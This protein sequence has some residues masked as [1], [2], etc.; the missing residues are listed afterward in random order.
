MMVVCGD[1]TQDQLVDAQSIYSSSD[2]L[3]ALKADGSVAAWCNEEVIGE[4][5]QVQ[6]QL[7]DVQAHLF[8]LRRIGSIEG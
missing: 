1:Q 5:S 8:H 4:C 2:A 6:V 7:V 3:A